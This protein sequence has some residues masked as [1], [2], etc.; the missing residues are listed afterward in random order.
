MEIL[1]W[2]SRFFGVGIARADLTTE[3]FEGA[4]R[5]ASEAGIECLSLFVP[6]TDLVVVQNAIRHGARLVDI[7]AELHARGASFT[8]SPGARVATSDDENRVIR[9]AGHLAETS[10]FRRDERFD[11]EHVAEMYRIWARQCLDRG[12]VAVPVGDR[13]GFVGLKGTNVDLVFVPPEESGRGLGRALVAT[14][15]AVAGCDDVTVA[16]QVSNVP[17]VRLYASLGFRLRRT[18]AILHLWL[19]E[20]T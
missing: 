13:R 8:V 4:L 1:E 12:V 2:D 16:T 6:G 3:T 20:F 15:V 7:R 5:A 9:A 18:T 11:P 19:D 14:A 17:A 10:R